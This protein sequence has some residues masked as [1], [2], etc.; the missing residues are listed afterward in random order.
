MHLCNIDHNLQ[1]DRKASAGNIM[2]YIQ[3]A[4]RELQFGFFWSNVGDSLGVYEVYKRW[5]QDYDS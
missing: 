5:L 4:Q 2:A 3:V 1:V